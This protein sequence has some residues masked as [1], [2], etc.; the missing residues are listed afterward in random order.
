MKIG[1]KFADG[2]E[3]LYYSDDTSYYNGSCSTC[4]YGSEYINDIRIETTNYIVNV[5]FN[6]M[7]EYAFS[8][9]E[10]IKMFAVN[11]SSMNEDDFIQYLN[12]KFHEIRTPERFEVKRKELEGD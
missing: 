1:I 5:E 3:F 2:N 12:E 8:T 6:A 7:Y 9:A 10:A 11:L 4:D